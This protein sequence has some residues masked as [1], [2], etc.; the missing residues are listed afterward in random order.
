MTDDAI[1]ALLIELDGI[2]RDVDHYEYGLP[3]YD[4]SFDRL[5]AAVR[6]ATTPPPTEDADAIG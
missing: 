1:R 6:S 2:A 3:L 4:E 5:A